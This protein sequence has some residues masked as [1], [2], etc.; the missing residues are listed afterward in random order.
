MPA[1]PTRGGIGP[2][3]AYI[4]VCFVWG[5]TYLAIR[6]AVETIPPLLMVGVR[7]VLAGLVLAIFAMTRGARPPSL[8]QGAL[9]ALGALLLFLGGQA[10][11]AAGE[12][13]IASGQA[14]VLG[15]MQALMMPLAAWVL[16]AAAAPSGATWLGLAAG[17][18]GVVILMDPG[19]HAVDAGGV[20]IVLVS[21][22]SW[23][24][25]GAVNRRWPAG[26]VAMASGLQMIVGGLACLAIS[27]P[28][29]AWHGFAL[30]QVSARSA[31]GFFYLASIGSL[32]GFSA[33]AWLVQIWPPARVAT[34]TYVNPVV[35]LAL[36]A[37]LAGEALTLRE[38]VAT[39]F[40]LGAIGIVMAAGRRR[41]GGA[42]VVSKE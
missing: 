33:F 18:A 36:G 35:A 10:M 19:A 1:T 26:N 37:W 42:A 15:A 24:F 4:A 6:M 22:V 11:L 13:R 20:A 29:G 32:V 9:L 25:G 5:S 2:I 28:E 41:A 12:Q 27:V 39:G 7:S 40:I 34:Y 8:R 16:G 14:A 38:V 31:A 30:S 3:A 23:S 21:V 17:F